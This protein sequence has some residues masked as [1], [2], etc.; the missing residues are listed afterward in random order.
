MAKDLHLNA[1]TMFFRNSIWKA[2]KLCMLCSYWI[3]VQL[4]DW[5]EVVWHHFT[6]YTTASCKIVLRFKWGLKNQWAL[7]SSNTVI[8]SQ[9]QFVSWQ[10]SVKIWNR[11]LIK[12][13]LHK[14]QQKV[15]LIFL[16]CSLRKYDV[17]HRWFFWLYPSA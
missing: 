7:L 10:L 6:T 5:H 1:A 14:H 8:F 15:I 9:I 2:M 11:L 16:G 13:I 3:T 4:S 17:R 12:S